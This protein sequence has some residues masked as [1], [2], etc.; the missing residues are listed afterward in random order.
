MPDLEGEGYAAQKRIQQAKGLR[1]LT[2]SQILSRLPI[3]LV[4]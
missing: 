2:P 3:S 4:Q 1:I